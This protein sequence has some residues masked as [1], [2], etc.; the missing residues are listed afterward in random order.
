[1]LLWMKDRE[2][3]LLM[4]SVPPPILMICVERYCAF[5]LKQ[6]AVIL[7]QKETYLQ[8]ELQAQDL[9]Y[10]T[11]G[12]RNPYR[13]AIDQETSTLYWG[14]VGPDAGEDSRHGPR[15]Y[16]EFNQ[17]KKPGYY[18]WP[19]FVGDNRAYHD[20]DFATKQVGELFNVNAPVNNS[21]NNTG[22]KQLTACHTSHD[23]VSL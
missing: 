10:Y 9:K 8:K 19:Y 14:E 11:M 1:M 2:E 23:I 21:V 12:C 18:G 17:A 4:R 13:I 7:F 20:S 16:D 6:M 3:K 22:M 5:I 15:G